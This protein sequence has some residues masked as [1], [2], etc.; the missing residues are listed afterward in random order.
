MAP[1]E[2]QKAIKEYGRPEY[3]RLIS[4]NPQVLPLHP[5]SSSLRSGAGIERDR[6]KKERSKHP[7]RAARRIWLRRCLRWLPASR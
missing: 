7:R 1:A 6:L 3:E 4:D 2:S 5:T